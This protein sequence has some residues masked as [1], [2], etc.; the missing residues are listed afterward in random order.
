MD[1]KGILFALRFLANGVSMSIVT[2]AF[3]VSD[4]E[5]RDWLR[6]GLEKKEQVNDVLTRE[7]KHPLGQVKLDRLWSLAKDVI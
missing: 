6:A 7:F 1:E 4:D 3:G 5:M 2:K